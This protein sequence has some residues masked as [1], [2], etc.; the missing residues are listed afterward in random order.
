VEDLRREEEIREDDQSLVVINLEEIETKEMTK[1]EIEEVIDLVVEVIQEAVLQ[2]CFLQRVQRVTRA[3]KYHF[4]PVV[5]SQCTVVTVLER[6]YRMRKEIFHEI[7]KIVT[8]KPREVNGHHVTSHDRH[9]KIGRIM[10]CEK[11][12]NSL[13]LLSH[14]SIESLMYSILQ[15]R[16]VKFQTFLQ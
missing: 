4:D 1:E 12:S 14:G 16:Q 10:T 11:L 8:Q 2:K 6:N 7:I 3:V 15:H 13:R 5:I 9:S